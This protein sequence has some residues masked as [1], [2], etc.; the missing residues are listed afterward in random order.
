M[1]A[2]SVVPA[3]PWVS[4]RGWGRMP[5]ESHAG[6]D[7][8][9]FVRLKALNRPGASPGPPP[10]RIPH[11]GEE[12]VQNPSATKICK[13]MPAPSTCSPWPSPALPPPHQA[14]GNSPGLSPRR[15]FEHLKCPLLEHQRRRR[16]L[17]ILRP[18][19]LCVSGHTVPGWPASPAWISQ[20]LALQTPV[21]PVHSQGR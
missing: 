3:S 18:G 21:P 11:A 9:G 7:N 5:M 20:S 13:D 15:L 12:A 16:F 8:L 1:P 17:A 19:D 4:E 14:L 6:Y 10:A 2:G